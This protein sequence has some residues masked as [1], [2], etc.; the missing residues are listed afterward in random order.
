M[1]HQ[2]PGTDVCNTFK[3]SLMRGR[4]RLHGRCADYISDI[5]D[6]ILCYDFPTFTSQIPYVEDIPLLENKP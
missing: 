4:F 2:P 1:C 3:S 6:Q 5:I